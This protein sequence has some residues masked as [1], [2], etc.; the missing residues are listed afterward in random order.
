MKSLANLESFLPPK[1]FL[2]IIYRRKKAIAWRPIRNFRKP[3]E[4]QRR[5]NIRFRF[6]RCPIRNYIFILHTLPDI[7]YSRA[8]RRRFPRV[9]QSLFQNR[10]ARNRSSKTRQI[11]MVRGKNRFRRLVTL[12]SFTIEPPIGSR[13]AHYWPKARFSAVSH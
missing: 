2:F 12:I 3:L 6:N 13:N 9:L 4:F 11:A 5:P 7:E 1:N 10:R 8:T